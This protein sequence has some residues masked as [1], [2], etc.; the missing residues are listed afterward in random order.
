MGSIDSSGGKKSTPQFQLKFSVECKTFRVNNSCKQTEL[1]YY[2]I[3]AI[4]A[5]KNLEFEVTA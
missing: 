1:F 5:N 3:V 2:D 4:H